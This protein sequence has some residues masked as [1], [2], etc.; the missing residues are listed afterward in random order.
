MDVDPSSRGLAVMVRLPH[1]HLTANRQGGR[2]SLQALF[3]RRDV[4]VT[5]IHLG[6]GHERGEISLLHAYVDQ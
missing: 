6:F 1:S 4:A 5:V 3:K 2:L